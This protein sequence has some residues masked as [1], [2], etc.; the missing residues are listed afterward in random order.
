METVLPQVTTPPKGARQSQAPRALKHGLPVASLVIVLLLAFTVRI[1]HLGFRVLTGDEAYSALVGRGSLRALSAIY[2]SVEPH[3]P[4]HY[5]VLVVWERL[6]G[7]SEFAVRFPS[8]AAGVLLVALVWALGRRLLTPAATTCAMLLIAG[9]P[10][11]VAYSQTARSYALTAGAL[12]LA[13]L[14]LVR[15]IERPTIWRWAAYVVAV[16]LA[17]YSH[18]FAALAVAALPLWY[19]VLPVGVR[20]RFGWR[21][22]IG[23]H[24]VIALLY[25][26]WVVRVVTLLGHPAP[27]WFEQGALL[28][29]GWK[30]LGTFA[31]GID[32]PSPV[33]DIGAGCLVVFTVVGIM[34]FGSPLS[35]VG[36]QPTSSKAAD[37][38][39]T[40]VKEIGGIGTATPSSV[41]GD[42]VRWPALAP[43]ERNE[44]RPYTGALVA[45]ALLVPL[46]LAVTISLRAPILR[47]RYLIVLFVPLI[48]I[49]SVG[50]ATFA[51]RRQGL[52]VSALIAMLIPS[53]IGLLAYFQANNFTTAAQMRELQAFVRE[54]A[55]PDLAIVATL[56]PA[57][58]FFKY[59]DLSPAELFYVP[60]SWG[61]QRQ[62]GEQLLREL[63]QTRSRIWLIPFPYGPEEARFAEPLLQQIAFR[64]DDRWFGNLRIVRYVTARAMGALRPVGATLHDGGGTITLVGY[65]LG[66]DRLAS[67]EIIALRLIWRAETTPTERFKVFVH[68]VDAAGV[69]WAQNDAEPLAG[70]FP[71]TLWPPGQNV[72]DQYSIAIPAGAPP[73]VY[74]LNVGLYRPDDGQRLRL[75]D[76]VNFLTLGPIIVGRRSPPATLEEAGLHYRINYTWDGALTLLGYDLDRPDRANP[77][78]ILRPG[79]ELPVI[80]LWQAKR[81]LGDYRVRLELRAVDSGVPS[82]LAA[83]IEG[84][85]AGPTYPTTD[86][87]VGETVLGQHR[88]KL[89][90]DARLGRYRLVAAARPADAGPWAEERWITLHQIEI[91]AP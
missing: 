90:P 5:L 33:A 21:L 75:P 2:K 71:T 49:A 55:G 62:A 56:D 63:V 13:M 54:A 42:A 84:A 61:E 64:L 29:L 91:V 47:D 36:R 45:V 7:S 66:A 65:Q 20:N 77:I 86:W 31:L 73:G 85:P 39:S 52:F 74:I 19:I 59:Y 70:H 37:G 68:L 38:L 26:P 22:W 24:L 43:G 40:E 27:M 67:G 78:V 69:R 79:E 14:A 35:V 8:A 17:L 10:Y 16:L 23:V 60:V 72:E 41:A 83:A 58:P 28:S 80:L 89:P 11:L 50:V 9:S 32:A 6:A 25:L 51:S 1:Y 88:L 46:V 34:K 87:Q 3:P 48:L 53:V 44:L 18:T 15:A 57:D 12:A 76:G 30:V 4:A 82:G 81:P